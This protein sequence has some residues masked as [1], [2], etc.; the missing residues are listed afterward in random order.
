[1]LLYLYL[2]IFEIKSEEISGRTCY[3][4]FSQN[5]FYFT[6]KIVCGN[7]SYGKTEKLKILFSFEGMRMTLLIF[8]IFIINNLNRK[9]NF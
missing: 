5:G 4:K 8:N 7:I 6:I 1:M 2:L 3:D 9:S